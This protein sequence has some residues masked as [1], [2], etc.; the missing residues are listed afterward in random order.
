MDPSLGWW[1]ARNL[2]L[3]DQAALTAS[4]QPSGTPSGGHS[5][6]AG[7][8]DPAAVK[9]DL[10]TARRPGGIV[11]AVFRALQRLAHPGLD[12]GDVDAVTVAPHH[13]VSNLLAIRGPGRVVFVGVSQVCATTRDLLGAA[14]QRVVGVDVVA[15]AGDRPGA[16]QRA[17][18]IT[19]GRKLLL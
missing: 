9:D 8:I 4:A 19:S 17:P 16:F 1:K 12:V 6:Q 7:I 2:P 3:G 13:V 5:V 11:A 18:G 14:S 10:R 15:A